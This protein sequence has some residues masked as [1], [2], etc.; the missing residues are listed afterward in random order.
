M[1]PRQAQII[2]EFGAESTFHGPASEKETYAFQA[3][4]VADNLRVVSQMPWLAGAIYWTA[5]EFYVKPDWDGGAR[6]SGVERD[7]LH[8][9]GLLHYDGTPKPAFHEARR[10]FSR[11]LVYR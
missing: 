10:L 7:A 2:T 1:Y 3:R 5:R 4:Y 8:N 11:T 6:R 9:K